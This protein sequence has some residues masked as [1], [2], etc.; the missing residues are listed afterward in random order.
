MSAV[1]SADGLHRLRLDREVQE[2]GPV[3][4]YFGINPS[5]ADAERDDP[6]VKKLREFTRINGGS[7]FIV[8][9][10][11]SYRSTD[12]RA[13]KKI[14]VRACNTWESL[15]HLGNVIAEADILVPMWGDVA[16]VSARHRGTVLA[17]LETLERLAPSLGKKL[18][19]FGVTQGGSPRHPQYLPYSTPLTPWPIGAHNA[20]K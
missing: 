17:L 9:N 1:L 7:R 14:D 15:V 4:A 20:A 5:T 13:L 16:K 8:A 10:V 19:H 3:F 2:S 18:L 11:F 6:T 12:V